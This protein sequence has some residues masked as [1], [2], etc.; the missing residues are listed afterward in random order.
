MPSPRL[1]RFARA[2]ACAALLPLA[3]PAFAETKRVEVPLVIPPAFLER[4]LVEQVFTDPETT[5]RIVARGDPCSE[6]V[7]SKPSLRPLGAR[8]FVTAHGRAQAG[9]QLFGGC[10]RPFDWEGEVEAEENPSVAEGAPA[11]EFRVSNSWLTDESDWLA[12]PA[13]WDWVKPAVHPRLET[14]RVDLAPLVEELRRAL[15]LFA[16]RREE[17][18]VRRLVESI[19]LS[20]VRVDDRGLVLRVRFDVEAV[21]AP[22]AAGAAAPEPPLAPEE[23]AAFEATL[24]EWDA[25]L[26]F[27]VKSAGAEAQGPA[28][29]SALLAVLLDSRHEIVAA[30][31][32]PSRDGEDRVRK[33]FLSSWR[34]LQPPLLSLSGGS[35]GLRY[36]AFVAAGDAL[37]A[38]D[39]AGPSFGLEIS[40]DGLR[41]LA[42][43]LVPEATEDPL[44]WSEEVDPA[45]R[46]TFG[47]E[48]ELPALPPP[49]AEPEVTAEPEPSAEPSPTPA[50]TPAPEPTPSPEATPEPGLEPPPAPGAALLKLRAFA[51]GFGRWLAP[52]AYAAPAALPPAGPQS[53]PLDGYVPRLSDLAHYLPEVAALLRE[54]AKAV[55]AGGKL[56][57]EHRELFRNLVLATAWQESCW[58]QYVSR[59]GKRVPLRSNVGALGLMQ[60]NPHVWRGFYS[61]DGLS[62]SIGYNA[63]AGGEILLHY[64]RDYAIARG[65]DQLGGADALARAAYAAYHGG[66]R[67]L[68]RYREP[69]RWRRA[70]VSV[71]RAF[72][73]KYQEVAAGRELA[74]RECF[75]G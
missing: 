11:V 51:A 32:E 75:P 18:A 44:A 42:R 47:F 57:R 74:V 59:S 46:A 3:A 19:A 10:Y 24:H 8:I 55:A 40:S 4:L 53:S 26:T 56:E 25:F 21:A 17:P 27:V 5:A 68:R 50:P 60:V 34:R 2:A 16:A 58:R 71:D 62:W 49:Q 65:E 63:R 1:V 31:A 29:R 6:I 35:E 61:V 48:A 41:R 37:S 23:I 30:L 64:L 73:E 72:H 43:T 20:D 33:L 15:P 22:A 36:L 39:Q 67:H 66:P 45:L 13:L 9:F 69:K 54:S 12:V 28:L 52:P 14:L 38:L 70:L 7:L